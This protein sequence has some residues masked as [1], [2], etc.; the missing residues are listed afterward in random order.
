MHSKG[1][2]PPIR[3]LSRPNLLFC[4]LDPAFVDKVREELKDLSRVR[5]T[6]TPGVFSSYRPSFTDGPARQLLSLLRQEALTGGQS[7]RLYLEHLAHALVARLFT[8]DGQLA[9]P[10]SLLEPDPKGLR[11]VIDRIRAN[12]ALEYNAE[13]LAA[14]T[15]YSASQFFRIFRATTGCTPYQYILRWR[16][17]R[18]VELMRKPSFALLDIALECGF[19]NEAHF[20]RTFRQRFGL[21]PGQ[22]RRE[23]FSLTSPASKELSRTDAVYAV[24]H[25]EETTRDGAAPG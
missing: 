13:D 16:M 24:N 25:R 15:G 11:H 17:K 12:P 23:K 19:V 4:A 20:S 7:G 10:S 2:I 14:E 21:P 8:L 5:P 22:F 9:A 6:G 18:A 1:A 3:P